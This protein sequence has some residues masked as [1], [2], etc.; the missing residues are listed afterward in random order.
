MSWDGI[1]REECFGDIVVVE[2]LRFCIF[3]LDNRE[4]IDIK[5]QK[6]KNMNR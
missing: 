2:V 6:K 1:K 4:M 5:K 3:T